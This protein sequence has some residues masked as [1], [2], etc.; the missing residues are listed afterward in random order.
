MG[1]QSCTQCLRRQLKWT[2]R[3]LLR[4]RYTMSPLSNIYAYV[5][6]L[7][8]RLAEREERARVLRDQCVTQN[9]V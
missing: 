4:P 1:E 5:K 3:L 2:G 9:E 8:S 6:P 7:N